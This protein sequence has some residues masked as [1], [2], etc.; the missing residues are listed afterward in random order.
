MS[1]PL[2]M[3]G[4]AVGITSLGI[5]VCQ[6]LVSYLQSIE[7]RGD[8]IADGLK[9]VQSLVSIFHSINDILPKIDRSQCAKSATVRNCLKESEEKLL[10]LQRLLL[11]L[12]GPL[13]DT[14]AGR[15]AKEAAR[16]LIYPFR[17]GSLSSLRQTLRALLDNLSLAI[18]IAS[19]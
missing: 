3:A 19:L 12:R 6:G 18:N 2:S 11:K 1:D 14:S 8:T 13:D 4:T 9:E 15:K 16:S 17:E 7:G 5:Q 10:E